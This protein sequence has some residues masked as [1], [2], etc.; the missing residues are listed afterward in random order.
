MQKNENRKKKRKKKKR[1]KRRK[2]QKPFI[3]PL[4][5]FKNAKRVEMPNITIKA[6]ILP[7]ETSLKIGSEHKQKKQKKK[8]ITTVNSVQ[9]K[10][11]FYLRFDILDVQQWSCL[12]WCVV[13]GLLSFLFLVQFNSLYIVK[14]MNKYSSKY[15]HSGTNSS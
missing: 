15:L 7:Q 3:P 9:R 13:I 6:S 10:C 1:K 12:S 11:T 4:P 5:P 2:I 8:L 14:F